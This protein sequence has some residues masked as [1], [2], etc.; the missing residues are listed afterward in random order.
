MNS[1]ITILLDIFVDITL[2]LINTGARIENVQ[3]SFALRNLPCR[4]D[5][6]LTSYVDRCQV[7]GIDTLETR[8]PPHR[9]CTLRGSWRVA[10]THTHR[11]FHLRLICGPMQVRFEDGTFCGWIG[12]TV[13]TDNTALYDSCR[14]ISDYFTDK[15][16]NVT[17]SVTSRTMFVKIHR[18]VL[19]TIPW[20][21]FFK[22]NC[23]V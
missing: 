18:T 9:P 11:N 2:L 14:L 12:Y 5:Q 3:M 13:V 22:K 19:S 6:C 1:K 21:T 17:S 10:L 8:R 16:K 23:I 4:E 15:K 20:W 7:L